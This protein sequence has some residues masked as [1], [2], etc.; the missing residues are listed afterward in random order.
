M[1]LTN[2]NV[3]PKILAKIKIYVLIRAELLFKVC[4]EIPCKYPLINY[5]VAYEGI[6]PYAC[7]VCAKRFKS[8]TGLDYHVTLKH[9]ANGKTFDESTNP[10]EYKDNPKLAEI[11]QRKAANLKKSVCILCDKAV[12]RKSNHI[13]TVH[14]DSEGK[15]KCPK[16]DKSFTSFRFAYSHART[17][18]IKGI[19]MSLPNSFNLF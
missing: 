19:S 14:T 8:K 7:H 18:H 3:E 17:V 2:E 6:M 12:F 4:H 1:G 9:D 16:C 5:L 11:L 10:E 13:K 15:V